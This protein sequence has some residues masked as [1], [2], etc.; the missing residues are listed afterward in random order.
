MRLVQVDALE[1]G[2]RM[3]RSIYSDTGSLL[4]GKGVVLSNRMINKLVDNSIFYVYIDD[5]I[6][7]GVEP[8]S[9][10][11]DGT[12]MKSINSVKKLMDELM[13]AENPHGVSKMIPLNTYKSVQDVIQEIMKSLENNEDVLYTVTELMGTDMYTYKHS[14]NVTILTIMTCK[15]MGYDYEM[16]KHI[17][18]GALLHDIGKVKVKSDLINK[19]GALNVLELKEIMNHSSYGY[20]MIK[21]DRV[22][23]P[24]TKLIV[25][26]HHEKL[27]G[28]GY[29]NNLSKEDIPE[30]VRVV[31]ICD[32]FDAMTSDRAYR[33]RMPIY[34]AMEELMVQA[35]YKLDARVYQKFI[36]QICIYPVGTEVELSD[37]RM[38]I[39]VEY[40]NHAP[41]RPLI[42]V[43]DETAEKNYVEVDLLSER[44][45]FI[46]NV[47]VGEMLYRKMESAVI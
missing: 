35:V 47:T 2:L 16:I 27:D 22:L 41:S 42:R 17:A 30:Y 3:G 4:L 32:M 23:S 26:Q 15:A 39:V 12:M 19:K 7:E 24:Y 33:A 8:I 13:T 44:T 25:H 6:S 28:S 20:D 46:D 38:A 5:E 9:V 18:M 29:P 37:G 1:P 36:Q 10:I 31:T 11:D 34:K 43:Y 40:R 45:V 14:V 21:D